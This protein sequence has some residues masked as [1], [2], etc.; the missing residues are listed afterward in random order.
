MPSDPIAA[1]LRAVLAQ[2]GISESGAAEA[3]GLA[4]SAV[5]KLLHRLEGGSEAVQL[6]TLKAVAQAVDVSWT[7]LVAGVGDPGAEIEPQTFGSLPQWQ[8]LRRRAEIDLSAPEEVW[9][10]VESCS[11]IDRHVTV[12]QVVD[13]ARLV[14]RHRGSL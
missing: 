6:D 11:P 1:R 14:L 2:K 5:S 10:F 3:A 8:E 13:F 12:A 4:R 9:A 7:W